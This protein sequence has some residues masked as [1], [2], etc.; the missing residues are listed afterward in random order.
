MHNV[1][2]ELN[3]HFTDAAFGPLAVVWTSELENDLGHDLPWPREPWAQSYVGPSASA[4]VLWVGKSIKS[5]PL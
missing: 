4:S 2:N 3:I 1:L 5:P